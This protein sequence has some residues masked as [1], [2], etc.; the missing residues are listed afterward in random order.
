MKKLLLSSFAFYREHISKHQKF[1]G[2]NL[3]FFLLLPIGCFKAKVISAAPVAYEINDYRTVGGAGQVWSNSLIWQKFNGA[4]WNAAGAD[5][6]PGAAATVYINGAV[7]TGGSRTAD[8][9]IVEANAALTVSSTMTSTALTLV[10]SGGSL[11]LNAAFT[12]NGVFEIEN[13]GSLLINYSSASGIAPIWN[14]TEKF[15]AGSTVTIQNW[16]YSAVSGANRLVQNP[17]QISPNADGFLFGNLIT[18]G[19]LTGGFYLIQGNQEVNFCKNNYTMKN[20]ANKVIFTDGVATIHIGGNMTVDGMQLSLSATTGGNAVLN[21]AGTLS[22]LSG[23]LNL[24]QT[25][26]SPLASLNLQGNLF[27]APGANLLSTAHNSKFNFTGSG[28]GLAAAQTVDVSDNSN[29]GSSY[30]DFVVNS[31]GYV[32]LINRNWG[33]GSVSSLTINGGATLD[34]GFNDAGALNVIRSSTATGFAT[35]QLFEAREGSTL[36]ITSPEGI[37]SGGIYSGNVRIGSTKATR[38]FSAAAHYFYIGKA[39]AAQ[40]AASGVDQVSGSGFPANLL[41]GNIV[42]DL[43]TKTSA[44]DDVSFMAQGIHKLTST[45]TLTILK[46]KVVDNAGNGFGEETNE[47]G[48]FTMT[49]GRYQIFRS[50]TQPPLGNA[51]NISGGVI[52]FAG[53]A[54]I[55]I[56]DKPYLNVEVSGTNV[57]IGPSKK[58]LELKPNGKFTV[59]KDAVLKIAN[60]DGF[61]GGT[62]TAI[63]STNNPTIILEDQSTI[64]YNRDGNQIITAFEPL[65]SDDSNVATGGY[66]NLKISGKN[67]NLQT[68]TSKK[69]ASGNAVYVRNNVEVA[70]DARLI[71][72]ADQTLTVRKEVINNGGSATNFIVEND[73]NLMQLEQVVNPSPISVRRLHQLSAERKQYNFV[74]SPV[75]GQHMKYIFGNNPANI[76]YSTVYNEKTDYFVNAKE[77]EYSDIAKGFSVKEPIKSYAGLAAESLAFNEAE[78]KGVPNN[79]DV[80]LSLNWTDSNHGYNLAGN[81]YPSDMDIVALYKNS[82]GANSIESTFYFWDNSINDIFT[83]MGSGYQGYSYA[84]FNAATGPDGYGIAAPGRK[85]KEGD[86]AGTKVPGRYIKVSQGFM[87][88]ALKPGATLQYKNSMRKKAAN[89]TEF[90]GKYTAQNSFRLEM[91]APSGVKLQNGFVYFESGNDGFGMEDSLLPNSEASDAL[92]SVAES[93]KVVI[94]G[95]SNFSVEDKIDLG[96]RHF[97]AGQYTIKAIDRDGIFSKDQPIYLIDN[98]LNVLTDISKTSYEFSS[99]SGEFSSRFEIAYRAEKTLAVPEKKPLNNDIII[100]RDG[101][102]LVIRLNEIGGNLLEL[103]DM[104][105]KLIYKA[106]IHSAETRIDITKFTRGIYIVKVSAAASDAKIKKLLLE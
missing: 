8:K 4:S 2:V 70:L 51:Y 36:K 97:S 73:G 91:T 34:F 55:V 47:S 19:A 99:E 27:V 26:N 88:R 41:S 11:I 83:Q 92:F 40:V 59:K 28:D 53:G 68:G 66:F 60:E 84:I 5:G 77:S 78:Y 31:G 103:F 20:T 14:G 79:G 6:I 9:I 71:I 23:S 13:N 85:E 98:H 104:G 38:I 44:A 101:S 42:I 102:E 58:G 95:K 10:K 48:N 32:K 67:G 50:D 18:S 90:F 46:G 89:N 69:L 29:S 24:N 25:S 82:V 61:S 35:G 56:R 7:D 105:G 106:K 63:N 16:N 96:T 1:F 57:S 93:E 72:D 17:S 21:V 74:S 12:N 3:L 100:F 30:I 33:L 94:N 64:E 86:L 43:D 52:E 75:K 15:S 76:P 37:I 87:V 39:N 45:G 65:T 62:A 22:V 81:P 49:G 54:A 80:N